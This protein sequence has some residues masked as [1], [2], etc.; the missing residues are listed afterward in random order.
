[1]ARH[2][3]PVCKLCRREGAKL[4]LKGERC[5]AAEKCSFERRPYPPGQHGKGRI[6]VSEYGKRLREKQKVRRVYGVMERQFLK[7]FKAA[8]RRKGV[9]GENL[10]KMLESRLDSVVFRMG[11]G[12]T[13]ADAR[14]LVRHNHVL[15]NGRRAIIPSRSIKPGDIVSLAP[16][17]R[18]LDRVQRA[19][20]LT[21]SRD[22]APWIEM[23]ADG[24]SGTF[25]AAPSRGELEAV[26]PV[27][28]NE[29]LV[30]EFYSR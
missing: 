11:L 3:G 23:A 16:N 20:E 17:S 25:R 13:R 27:E 21:G 30:V 19:A 14:Q 12:A 26:Q 9:T 15:V 1:M 7:C 2:T 8:A 5:Y 4:F 18:K 22:R 28:I 24:L 6:K 29:Q 10:L